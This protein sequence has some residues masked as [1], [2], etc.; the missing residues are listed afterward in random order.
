MMVRRERGSSGETQMEADGEAEDDSFEK[1]AVFVTEAARIT[2]RVSENYGKWATGEQ[3]KE[4]KDIFH[5]N[6]LIFRNFMIGGVEE[7][8]M[9]RS[10]TPRR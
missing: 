3:C 9:W 4:M 10:G 1:Y 5:T 2:T 7:E 8:F 6:R